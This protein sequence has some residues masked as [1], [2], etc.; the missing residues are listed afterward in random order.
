M[1]HCPTSLEALLQE[2]NKSSRRLS[3]E[4]FLKCLRQFQKGLEC[5]HKNN[6]IHRD[7]KPNN[8]L[9]GH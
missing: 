7:L 3:T 6:A 2:H 4:M 9:L 5:L 1:E 8:A